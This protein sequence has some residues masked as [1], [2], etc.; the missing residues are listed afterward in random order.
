[1]DSVHPSVYEVCKFSIQ[2]HLR[3]DIP[4][5]PI[6][7]FTV[8]DYDRKS[9]VYESTDFSFARFFVPQESNFEGFSMFVDADFIFLEDVSQLFDV[10]ELNTNFAVMCCKHNYY[11]PRSG[12]KMDGK[13]QSSFNR[14]NW[15][16]LMLFNNEHPKIK[17]LNTSTINGQSGKFL[18]QFL[19]LEDDEIGGIPLNWNWLV[20]YYA[21]FPGFKPNAI[22]YTD[23]GPWLEKYKD[24]EYSSIYDTY[25]KEYEQQSS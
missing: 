5:S 6:N 15:S 20:G 9:D 22:H 4:I 19:Y 2:K 11:V 10:H 1:M 3:R 14:K 25:R 8:K 12:M 7:K 18:H 24:C 17:T 13:V 23:G 16:S 21:E